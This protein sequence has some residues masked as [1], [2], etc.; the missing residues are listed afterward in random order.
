[1]Q[2]TDSK[3]KEEPWLDIFKKPV[4]TVAKGVAREEAQAEETQDREA[5]SY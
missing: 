1:M 4:L 3:A 5:V 2:Q